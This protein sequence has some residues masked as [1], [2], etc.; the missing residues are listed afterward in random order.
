M[1]AFKTSLTETS[2][3]Q[4][5]SRV[6]ARERDT[7]TRIFMAP[8]KRV[9]TI[10]VHADRRRQRDRSIVIRGVAGQHRVDVV[11]AQILY[12]D[13]AARHAAAVQRRGA[14]GDESVVA[15]PG[16]HRR[17]LTCGKY[18]NFVLT[19]CAGARARSVSRKNYREYVS[20]NDGIHPLRGEGR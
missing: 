3:G 10:H 20:T 15:I 13:L 9:L 12:N 14:V 7:R 17:R 5:D 1:R 4:R 19:R 11:P 8:V 2:L 16:H 18:I 6:S